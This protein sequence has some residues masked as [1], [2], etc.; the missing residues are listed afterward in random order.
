M[1]QDF[2]LSL[3]SEKPFDEKE[4]MCPA[5]TELRSRLRRSRVTAGREGPGTERPEP[6]SF[7]LWQHKEAP[8]WPFED[9]WGFSVTISTCWELLLIGT[10]A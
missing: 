9:H 5:E 3:E 1:K 2:R 10:E 8:R 4:G 6:F 7:F